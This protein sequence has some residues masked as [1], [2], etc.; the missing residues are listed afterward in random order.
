[1]SR[2]PFSRSV[3]TEA[4]ESPAQSAAA[5]PGPA[6]EYPKNRKHF[7]PAR[8]KILAESQAALRA[9]WQQRTKHANIFDRRPAVP[10]A[11]GTPPRRTPGRTRGNDAFD[12]T[13]SA[14]TPIP[15]WSSFTSPPPPPPARAALAARWRRPKGTRSVLARGGVAGARAC[16]SLRAT[17]SSAAH[18]AARVTR[19][20]AETCAAVRSP[21]FD[22]LVRV[23]RW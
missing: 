12:R 19:A 16:R 10:P 15:A 8:S 17:S 3:S 2:N 13:R 4:V 14:V 9:P 23:L 22:A 1:M 6:Q 5:I 20:A 11:A 18:G 7:R 21:M